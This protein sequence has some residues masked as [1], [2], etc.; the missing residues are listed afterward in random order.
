MKVK[1]LAL[2]TVLLCSNTMKGSVTFKPSLLIFYLSICSGYK[3][4]VSECKGSS[5]NSVE[6]KKKIFSFWFKNCLLT[7]FLRSK[8]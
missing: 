6:N 7:I 8:H 3:D 2:E 5:L 4:E 1:L